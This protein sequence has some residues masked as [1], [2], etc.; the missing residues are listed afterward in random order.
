MTTAFLLAAG[1]GKRMGSNAGP[2][3]LLN[4]GGK[5]LLRR[6]LESLRSV[7]VAEVALVVGFRAGEVE[8]EARA[9]LGKMKLTVLNNPRYREGAVLSLWTAREFLDREVLVM[10]ADVLCPLAVFERLFGS[11]HENCLVADGSAEETGE[12]QMLFGRAGRVLHIAKRAP[13]GIRREMTLYG[14]SL[15]FLRLS[16]EGAACLRGLLE[17]KVQA[18]IVTIEHEQVYQDLFQRVFVGF[19]R[20][21][22]LPWT[23][24]DTPEDLARAKTGVPAH[25]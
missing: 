10:D 24:I 20:V 11:V 23:E 12:E 14:E 19:E 8:R 2:K 17:K 3:C 25:G 21:D 1:V 18:G 9:H 5:S 4:V 16:R 7:G 22:G 6:T 13:E 15:G